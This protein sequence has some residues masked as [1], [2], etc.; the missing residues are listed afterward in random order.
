M[1]IAT[2]RCTKRTCRGL[3]TATTNGF[4]ALVV[5]CAWCDRRQRGLCRLCPLPVDGT[6]G[7]AA[8]CATHRAFARKRQAQ[9]QERRNK[10]Q[11]LER[12]RRRQKQP[13]VRAAKAAWKRE[14]AKRNPEKVKAYRRA[15][16]LKQTPGYIAGYRRAN[17]DPVR[18]ALK[19][20]RAMAKYYEL[21]P[22]RPSPVCRLCGAR[23]QFTG[24]GRPRVTC[25]SRGACPRAGSNATAHSANH[26]HERIA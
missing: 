9:A 7:K 2:T 17:A 23:I 22:D 24:V 4:G 26:S 18:A 21:R 11:R 20:E 8:Y 15:Y 25:G 6:V 5:L 3:I 1:T 10:E 19:R 16:L 13:A 14:W 12:A